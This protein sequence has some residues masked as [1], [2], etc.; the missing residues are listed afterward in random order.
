MT[1]DAL[2]AD[3]R[4]V[5]IGHDWG[6]YTGYGV[7]ASDPDAF[8]RLIT[9][10]VPPAPALATSMF[11]Y[12]QIKRS[13]YIWFIQQVARRSHAVGAGILGVAVGGFGRRDT[14][15]SKIFRGYGNMSPPKRS[16][17]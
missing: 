7:V 15:L 6:A 9:L 3:E 5:L 16:R 1:S 13:F 8:S 14:M 12:P 4:A 2:K 10:A 17:G 11:S